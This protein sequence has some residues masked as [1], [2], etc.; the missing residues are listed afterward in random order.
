MNLLKESI[1]NRVGHV[2][3]S[4]HFLDRV[5]NREDSNAQAA[6]SAFIQ[7]FVIYRAE[8]HYE[9]GDV[10]YFGRHPKFDELTEDEAHCFEPPAYDASFHT[11]QEEHNIT[12]FEVKFDRRK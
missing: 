5:L 10:V 8:R 1:R 6:W 3:V 2:R 4:E 7:D 9:S 11:R 12:T